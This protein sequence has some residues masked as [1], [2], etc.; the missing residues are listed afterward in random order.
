VVDSRRCDVYD[1]EDVPD[2][3]EVELVDDAGD[4][5]VD[6]DPPEGVDSPDVEES[7]FLAVPSLDPLAD[8]ES[9]PDLRES[10]R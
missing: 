10:L 5:A 2:V 1:V 6:V 8:E 9:E 3:D 4:D 7:A